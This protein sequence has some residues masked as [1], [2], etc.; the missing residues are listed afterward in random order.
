MLMKRKLRRA[1]SLSRGQWWILTR[2][3]VLLLLVDLGLRILPFTRLQKIL[4]PKLPAVE[5]SNLLETLPTIQYLQRWVGTAARN[6]LYPMTCLRRALVLQWLLA[7]QGIAVNLRFGVRK[8]AGTLNAHAWLEHRGRP[9]GEP[10]RI[11]RH[12]A[13]LMASGAEQ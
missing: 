1:L 10:Q 3:W 2:A 12:Y 7:R 4:T 11:A 13:P 5:E 8:E 6:H 9:I